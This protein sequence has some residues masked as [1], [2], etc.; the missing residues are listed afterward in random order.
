MASDGIVEIEVVLEDGTAQKGFLRL[1]KSA[2][3][4]KK[5][6]EDS[7][8][9]GVEGAAKDAGSALTTLSSNFGK[10]AAAARAFAI[11][12]AA[13][14]AG[15]GAFF[16]AT[17]ESAKI[18]DELKAINSQFDILAN[19][20]GN[21]AQS[22]RESFSET[23]RGLVDLDDILKSS[24]VTL[25][26]LEISASTLA[27]N[28][29][30]ARQASVAFGVDTVQAYEA[31]NQAIITGNT[32]G[33]R[34]LGLFIDSKDA[35]DKYAKSLGIAAQFLNDTGRQQAIANAIAEKSSVVF[36][37][38]SEAQEKNSDAGKRL[39]VSFGEL[40][41]AAAAFINTATGTA[42]SDALN[43]LAR[44]LDKL[45]EFLNPTKAV[46]ADQQIKK[47]QQA[48]VD[49]TG[50]ID[51]LTA[52]SQAMGAGLDQA[53]KGRISELS[54]E[55][56][57]LREQEERLGMAQ[58]RRAQAT[59]V[60][61][62]GAKEE[63]K[64]TREQVLQKE[65]AEAQKQQ[66]EI[67][68]L[69]MQQANAQTAMANAQTQ[70]EFDEAKRQAELVQIRQYE[71]NQDKIRKE[72]A[73]VGLAG[74]AEEDAALL[75]LQEQHSQK[76]KEIAEKETAVMTKLRGVV[77]AGIVNGLT[78][79]FAGL[80]KA[81]V[82]G[83][84]GFEAMGKAVLGA[85]GAMAIQIGSMLVAIGLG[86]SAL[87]PVMPVFG[88]S[89]AAAVA[90]GLG[91]I[92]LGGAL[93]AMGEG[94]ETGAGTA[95]AGGGGV[96]GNGGTA[97]LGGVADGTNLEAQGPQTQIAV[98]VQGNILDRRQ[99]GIE[100]VEVIREQFDTQGGQTIVGMA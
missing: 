2:E 7:L 65:A 64:L 55:L 89:G 58:M 97:N 99:T 94:G 81:L 11:P 93:S 3:D 96:V 16:A 77:Q 59:D 26:S 25:G 62:K 91:L 51:K 14:G 98:N 56:Q 72:Y 76:M 54:A 13:I 29:K 41:E 21:S 47:V 69:Q 46:T 88:L 31:L 12:L 4:F 57:K 80:G 82:K 85:M 15:V 52:S 83:Q 61:N 18:V 45:T 33:L 36:Q 49:L 53:T 10:A 71:I 63:T 100:L 40:R 5:S 8:G 50:D 44:S 20:G 79:A 30:I 74:K 38:V 17:S 86:F 95:T 1:K 67:Q 60:A 90:A 87:G 68:R 43:F 32:R 27:D 23:A 22:L 48:I 73:A 28:F 42:A 92:V 70:A 9:K 37:G 39:S 84:N 78:N 75:A 24:N 66:L 34:Q 19:R 6:S 35:V